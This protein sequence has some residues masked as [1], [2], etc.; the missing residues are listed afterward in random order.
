MSTVLTVSRNVLVAI[1]VS[2]PLAILITILLFPFWTWIEK[3]T[4]IE[5]IGHS[6]P[7]VWCFVVSYAVV[8]AGA[9]AFL[10]KRSA[11]PRTSSA[12]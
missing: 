1:V 8:L 5:S 11:R 10:L 6:G 12:D 7:A 3:T 2:L 4:G 9:G